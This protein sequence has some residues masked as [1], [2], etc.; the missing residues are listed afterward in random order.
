MDVV[1]KKI[2]IMLYSKT[3]II[4]KYTENT[5][6]YFVIY[7][8]FTP[9]LIQYAHIAS[10]FYQKLRLILLRASQM[11]NDSEQKPNPLLIMI[12]CH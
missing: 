2:R 5:G 12:K 8:V 6:Y 7:N 4:N 3:S 10:I 11:T 9:Q 1:F